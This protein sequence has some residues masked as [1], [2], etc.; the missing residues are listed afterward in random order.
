MPID[1]W[2]QRCNEAYYNQADIGKDF[3]TAPEI[4]PL[5]GEVIGGWLYYQWQRLKYPKAINIVELGAG[6]GTLMQDAFR[7]IQNL[8][9]QR[10][11]D[12]KLSTV[13]CLNI[14]EQST[15]LKKRQQ[16][17]IKYPIKYIDTIEQLQPSPTLIIANEFFDAL[18]VRQYH[19]GQLQRVDYDSAH[20]KFFPILKGNNIQEENIAAQIIVTSLATCLKQYSGAMIMIDYGY[21]NGEKGDTLQAVKDHQYAD[22]YSGCG[23]VDLTAHVDFL[24][25]QNIL[26]QH[27]LQSR[28]VTQQQFLKEMGI[29]IRLQQLMPRLKNPQDSINRVQRLLDP[30]QMGSLFKVLECGNHL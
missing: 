3:T 29:E 5:F 28:V 22:F 18:P 8:D 26:A 25:L 13:M 20:N 1:Q 14:L 6:N 21:C 17:A 16:Q 11:T 27:A 7:A 19:D 30:Q 12:K 24:A 10:V 2:M 4:S 15:K 9:R 23:T